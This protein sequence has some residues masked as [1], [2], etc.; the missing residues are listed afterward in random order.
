MQRFP[1][2]TPPEEAAT[3]MTMIRNSANPTMPSLEASG[4]KMMKSLTHTT[5]NNHFNLIVSIKVKS[6]SY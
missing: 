1:Q 3:A 4:Y 5:N 2:S 6:I